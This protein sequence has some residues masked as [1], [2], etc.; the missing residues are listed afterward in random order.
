MA[1][2]SFKLCLLLLSAFCLSS[3]TYWDNWNTAAGSPSFVPSNPSFATSSLPQSS[4]YGA[5][6]LTWI[7]LKSSGLSTP[8]LSS[9]KNQYMY[10]MSTSLF[11]GQYC[12]LYCG[13]RS[14]LVV[15]SYGNL[16]CRRDMSNN[17]WG[18]IPTNYPEYCVP[19]TFYSSTC[20]SFIPALSNLQNGACNLY[21]STPYQGKGYDCCF[22]NR[23]EVQ[24]VIADEVNKKSSAT[25]QQLIQTEP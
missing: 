9:R 14:F 17:Y 12:Q 16:V 3:A 15:D 18:G 8:P 21:F 1:S 19:D 5:G 20:T 10:L 11:N 23:Y 6:A 13:L 22:H 24:G 4:S 2:F 7:R 25:T